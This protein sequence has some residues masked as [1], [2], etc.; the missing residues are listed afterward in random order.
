MADEQPEQRTPD[1][2]E[3]LPGLMG[4]EG[5]DE[6][7]LRQGESDVPRQGAE[8]TARG[9]AGTARQD[10]AGQWQH[11]RQA[12]DQ[13][14][15]D[16]P[17]KRARQRQCPAR[18]QGYNGG[19]RRQRA[20]Q[21][22]EHL[23][24]ADRRHVVAARSLA[25][26]QQPRQQLPVATRPAM[27]P[28]RGNVVAGGKL[29]D[30]L[31]VGRQSGARK[32]AF[33][34]IVAED[35][36]F[37]HASVE[38][39]LEGIDVVDALAGIRALAEEILVDVRDR[40]R[41]G[42][43]AAVAGEDALEER[44]LRTHGQRGGHARLQNAVALHD[45]SLRRVEARAV[46]RVG[47]LADQAAHG[48]AGQPGIRIE[49]DHIAHVRRQ[50]ADVGPEEGRFA[51][52][53]QQPVQ[54]VEL[55]TLALPSHPPSLRR[56]PQAM[57]VEQEKAVA[58]GDRRVACIETGDAR[59][60]HGQQ[61]AVVGRGFGGGIAPIRQQGE[62]H[63]AGW[64]GQVVDF[65]PFDQLLDAGPA[66]QQRRNGHQCA[67]FGRHTVAKRQAGQK[68]CTKAAGDEPIDQHQRR[69]DGR[70]HAD[71]RHRAQPPAQNADLR[72]SQQRQEEDD[73]RHEGNAADITRDSGG[74]EPTDER[75]AVRPDRERALEGRPAA[76]DQVVA[77]IALSSVV[78]CGRGGGRRQ[79]P[80]RA[81]GFA[82]PRAARH[83]L[84]GG[85]I[86]IAGGEIHLGKRAA[87]AQDLVDRTDRLEELG[88]V[89]VRDQAHAGDD[90]AHGDVGC[91]LELVLV[92]DQFLGGRAVA[93]QPLLEP[94]HRRRGLGILVA[95]P[96]DQLHDEAFG[97]GFAF[98][99]RQHRRIGC[100]L[101]HAEQP[102]GHGIGLL[103][104]GA[105]A[106]D[107]FGGAPEV[108]DQNEA[109]GDRHRPQLADAEGLDGLIGAHEPRQ[110]FWI[111]PAVG[112]GDERPGDTEDPRIAGQRTAAQLRQLTIISRRQVGADLT[113]LFFDEM[114]VVEEPF[115]G[116]RDRPA[117]GGRLGDA[118]IGLEQDLLVLPQPVDE[119]SPRR[120]FGV[121]GLAGRQAL[122]MLLEPLDAE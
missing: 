70:G 104:I 39:R 97:Q 58:A 51:R 122:G 99:G 98:V 29:L 13:N 102:V 5:H 108:L 1:R 65:Q 32:H 40:R 57:A 30:H 95:Q 46:E 55:A 113:D 101:V 14:D 18:Q 107:A 100:G 37:R 103:A 6:G 38:R 119:T 25:Q 3:H 22:V 33:E 64:I 4:E 31:D 106:H 72:K 8:M 80:P 76:A 34:Q 63:G 111:E 84:D 47:H 28:G 66:G 78:V 88:P 83:P 112:V 24:E 71:E 35:G 82:Q 114:V 56:V 36:I 121:D 68:G 43:D 2:I 7:G 69:V 48:I 73:A 79:C 89:D 74:R 19:R 15:E 96:L 20:A 59:A 61:L 49:G 45:P 50:L 110:R 21:I 17:D 92:A 109:Q 90:V 81:L 116:R 16:R 91:A 77:G 9:D 75:Q 52:S 44:A 94:A 117:L 60:R 53:A 105:P 41:I 12:Q 67:K 86:E 85:A 27:L 62:V 87:G 120:A 11:G 23:P 26:A 93:R 54:F 115:R 10:R 118:A 42:I